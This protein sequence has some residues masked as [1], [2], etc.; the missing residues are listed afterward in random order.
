M[1][2]I[3]LVTIIIFFIPGYNILGT[4]FPVAARLTLKNSTQRAMSYVVGK[5]YALSTLGAI[6]GFTTGFYLL[7]G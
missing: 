6:I 7:L 3:F 1:M 2:R 4:I 5:I